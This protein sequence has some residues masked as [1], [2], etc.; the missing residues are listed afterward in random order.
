MAEKSIK[1]KAPAKATGARAEKST[2][3]KQPGK[4]SETKVAP[5]TA[6]KEST[7]TLHAPEAAQVFVAGSFN[8]WDPTVNPLERDREGM[9]TCAVLLEPGEYEYRFV[10]DDVWWDD[11]LNLSRRQ[12][13]FG[14]ENCVLI[15]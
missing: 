11:P 2:K 9:W 10:V 6:K 8:N 15:S 5:K 1:A 3:A 12:T 4:A 13:E 14:C 7:F